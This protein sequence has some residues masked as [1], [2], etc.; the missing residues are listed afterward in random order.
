MVD[1]YDQTPENFPISTKKS[2]RQGLFSSPCPTKPALRASQGRSLPQTA[3]RLNRARS[4]LPTRALCRQA[5]LAVAAAHCH[6]RLRQDFLA[7]IS[8]PLGSTT[9][10]ERPTDGKPRFDCRLGL[11]SPRRSRPVGHD[12]FQIP[13]FAMSL[14][15]LIRQLL[16][17]VLVAFHPLTPAAHFAG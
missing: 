8:H 5:R 13:D 15:E 1:R 6:E 9:C 11:L 10:Q 14:P 17:F 7:T 2:A 12:S 4:P 16:D 3:I